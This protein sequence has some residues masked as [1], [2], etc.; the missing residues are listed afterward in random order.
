MFWCSCIRTYAPCSFQIFW[1]SQKLTFWFCRM[2]QSAWLKMQNCSNILSHIFMMRSVCTLHR[3]FGSRI[4]SN[5][6]DLL[7]DAILS[8]LKFFLYTELVSYLPFVCYSFTIQ[9]QEVA[10]AFGAVCTPEF[11]LFKKVTPLSVHPLKIASSAG[12][13]ICAITKQ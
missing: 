6:E 2:V 7:F 13:L 10:K 11:F 3:G 5:N 12:Y 8:L 4:I 9:S 1:L